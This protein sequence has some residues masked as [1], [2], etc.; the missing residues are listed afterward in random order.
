MREKIIHTAFEL[1]VDKGYDN[2]SINDIVQKA[3]VSKGGLYHH[4]KNKNELYEETLK[5]YFYYYYNSNRVKVDPSAS[6]IENLRRLSEVFLQPFS[7]MSNMLEGKKAELR[8]YFFLIQSL[9]K[10]SQ[11]SSKVEYFNKEIEAYIKKAIENAISKKEISLNIDPSVT[12]KMIHY[13]LEGLAFLTILK[14]EGNVESRYE[15]VLQNLYN[16]VLS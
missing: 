7:D 3:G 9:Q 12:A 10:Q 11:M 2:V 15:E 1:F 16:S 6:L 5:H 14:K 8:Y 13:T 4:F